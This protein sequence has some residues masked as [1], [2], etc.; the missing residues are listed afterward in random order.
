M[1]EA[2]FPNGFKTT[3]LAGPLFLYRD[4]VLAI[5][6]QLAAIG[7]QTDVQF[8][9][10]AKWTEISGNPWKGAL[11]YSNISESGNQ[12]KSF[13]YFVGVPAV[14]WKSVIRPEGFGEM[15]S[16]SEATPEQDP[17]MLKKIAKVISDN[18]MCIPV[19]SGSILWAFDKKV[20]DHGAG[21]RG[22][23]NWYEPQNIWFK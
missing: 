12:N 21:T 14:R 18:V 22:Q 20:Q 3:I 1:A 9:D 17:V 8:P 16:V 11:L 10:M 15:L 5:Q 7:I 6:S 2:G 19:Y 23:S 4:T 13:R